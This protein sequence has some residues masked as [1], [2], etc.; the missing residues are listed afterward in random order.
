MSGES[1]K[2]NVGVLKIA[3]TLV[4]R[5]FGISFVFNTESPIDLIALDG[6]NTY[7]IQVKYAKAKDG[8]ISFSCTKGVGRKQNYLEN[9]FDFYGVYCPDTNK[10]YFLKNIGDRNRI[11]L[12]IKTKIYNSSVKFVEDYLLFPPK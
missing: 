5:G 2:G 10:C 12:T 3:E 4:E 7:R 9:E 8:H 11:S 6:P 1:R